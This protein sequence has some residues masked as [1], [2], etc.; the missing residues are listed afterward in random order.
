V[1]RNSTSAPRKDAKTVTWFFVVDVG[2][3]P[4]GK[5]RQVYPAPCAD[6]HRAAGRAVSSRVG[7]PVTDEVR[8]LDAD[9]V[10]SNDFDPH[11]QIR[12]EIG[13][14]TRTASRW[15]AATR[16]RGFL[17]PIDHQAEGET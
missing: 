1:T 17:P 7:R 12:D 14:S 9:I 5:R 15:I 3:G 4:D 2:P 16:Q 6:I 8:R 11:R 10:R 13:G